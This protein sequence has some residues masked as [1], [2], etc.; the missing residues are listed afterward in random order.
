MFRFLH[1]LLLAMLPQVLLAQQPAPST[2]TVPAA[3]LLQQGERLL[4]AEDPVLAMESFRM[5]AAE[6]GAREEAML[7]I[8]KVHLMLG[9]A[10]RALAHVEE[11][12]G[13]RPADADAHALLVR[14][15]IRARRFEHAVERAAGALDHALQPTAELLAA[16]ASSLFRV[17]RTGEAAE[18]YRSVLAVQSLH[19]EAHLRLG[20]GLCDPV[21]VQPCADL[22]AADEL[23]QRGQVVQAIELL[24][25]ALAGRSNPVAHRLLGEVLY[26]QR[27]EGSMAARPRT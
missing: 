20:S 6:P 17:Q 27:W 26:Q 1:L 11:V 18:R 22:L 7:G 8:G 15:L 21:E 24:Q 5:L 3:G 12:L 16:S 23:R 10:D 2:P 9:H 19:A 25:R 4:D 13:A 14:S